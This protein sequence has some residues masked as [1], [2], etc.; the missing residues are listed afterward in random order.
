MQFGLNMECDYL[1]GKTE[2]D[3]FDDVFSQVDMAE[4]VGLDSVWLAERHFASGDRG[5]T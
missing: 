5:H 4:S 2:Q 3:A 1:Q